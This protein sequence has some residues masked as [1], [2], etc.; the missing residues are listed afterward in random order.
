MCDKEDYL[1]AWKI[2]EI[3]VFR[4]RFFSAFLFI[5][6]IRWYFKAKALNPFAKDESKP[7]KP[8]VPDQRLRDKVLKQSFDMKKVPES[9]DIVLLNEIYLKILINPRKMETPAQF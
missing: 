6:I 9:I 5:Q 2:T 8:Y 1:M 7:R 4:D 3:K